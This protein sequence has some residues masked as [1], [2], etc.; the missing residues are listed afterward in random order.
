MRPPGLD[1]FRQTAGRRERRP[2]QGEGGCRAL[3]GCVPEAV[4]GCAGMNASRVRAITRRLLQQ[5][6]RD[7]RTLALLF[8]APLVILA[9]LGYLL[10]GGG[11]VPKMGVVNLDGGPLGSLV[12]STL[13][14]SKTGSASA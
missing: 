3:G 12:T 4:R 6:R 14:G 13:E 8:G 2:G 1:P 9:L 7:H 5:F 10:R 11:D